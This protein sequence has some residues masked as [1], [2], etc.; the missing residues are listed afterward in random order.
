MSTLSYS[1][2]SADDA[3]PV[4]PSNVARVVSDRLA[5]SHYLPLRRLR[6][7]WENG[8]LT[9]LGRVPTFF[10]RQLAWS[11]VADFQE[12]AHRVDKIEVI[13][14]GTARPIR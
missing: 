11:L 7:R 8:T 14:P 4:E 3:R 12:I 5:S 13:G 10:L 1:T 9:L 6:C 2:L